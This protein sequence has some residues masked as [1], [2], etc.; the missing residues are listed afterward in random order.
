M[1]EPLRD[2]LRTNSILKTTLFSQEEQ[3][4][5]YLMPEMVGKSIQL[6]IFSVRD[7]NVL[8]PLRRDI[9]HKL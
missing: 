3:R 2:Q 8:I 6:Q 7:L 5:F 4:T 9:P 1:E